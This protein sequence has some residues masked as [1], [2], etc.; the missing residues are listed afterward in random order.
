MKKL[1]IV[2]MMAL[3]TMSAGAQPTLKLSAFV[4]RVTIDSNCWV[5][6]VHDSAGYK[7]NRKFRQPYTFKRDTIKVT[8][9]LQVTAPGNWDSAVVSLD[10]ATGGALQG[11]VYYKKNL[12]SNV[13]R[14]RG[15]LRPMAAN[16]LYTT[17]SSQ[18]YELFTLPAGYRPMQEAYFTVHYS[19]DN[20]SP[21]VRDEASVAWLRQ[22]SAYVG[23]DGIVRLHLLRPLA[24]T[25]YRVTFNCSVPLD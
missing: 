5:V 12:T 18:F 22:F 19:D 15:I 9:V 21:D 23:T 20:T 10:S 11:T 8:K 16:R 3:M 4:A 25:N 2:A 14:L 7:V 6:G 13:L 24:L 17:G 1:M